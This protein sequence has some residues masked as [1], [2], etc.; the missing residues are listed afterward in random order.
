VPQAQLLG[1]TLPDPALKWNAARGDS[2]HW[3]F[4]AIDWDD[5]WR[6]VG[7]DGPC[8]RERLDERVRAWDE[9]AWVREA[10]MAHARK[11]QAKEAAA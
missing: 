1:V 3:D 4:G 5:F 7:G 9:G 8:N 6:V 11:Q 10:A 2:G